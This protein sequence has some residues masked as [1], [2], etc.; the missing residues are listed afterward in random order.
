MNELLR[1]LLP[2]ATVL[3][4]GCGAGSFDSTA[5]QFT[6]VR[7]D[8][9]PGSARLPNFVRADAARLPFRA[10]CFDVVV[11]NHS[12]E[13]V[14]NLTG[15]LEE[16]G[17]ILKPAGSL[18]V[19]VPDA[20]TITDRLYRWLAHGG[21]HV[22]P[23]S[24]APELTLKIERTT[25]LKHA[26]TRTL[27]TSFSFLNRRNHR[28]PKRLLLFGGGTPTS[29]HFWNYLFRML[30]RLLGTRLSIYGWAFYFGN[31]D[32]TFECVAWTNVCIFCGAGHPSDC[33]LRERRVV[34]HR[35]I[36]AYRCP[37]CRTMNLLTND[38]RLTSP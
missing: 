12:L 4:L 27:C 33:L 38:R 1:N 13:H 25:G 22:N 14:E 3:D 18:Y 36:P 17:R 11:S 5:S 19:A 24:S 35:L 37:G 8:L 20:T 16:I 34:K 9:E 32:A 21:G 26:A 10:G 2:G 23:F 28:V 15:A 29:L 31:I 7:L 6:T 30:D